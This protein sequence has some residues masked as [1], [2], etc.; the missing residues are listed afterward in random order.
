MPR[1]RAA[2]PRPADVA[3][4]GGLSP[5]EVLA[6]GRKVVGLSQARRRQGTLLQAGVLMELDAA[7]LARVLGGGDGLAA[8]LAAAAAGLRELVPGVEPDDV[9]AAVNP[10]LAGRR[11]LTSPAF[12][13][14]P[15]LDR[16]GERRPRQRAVL[17][18]GAGQAGLELGLD[19]GDPAQRRRGDALVDAQ[20]LG[21]ERDPPGRRALALEAQRHELRRDAVRGH[22]A[23]E[24]PPQG[25]VEGQRR[26]AV[27]LRRSPAVSP[28]FIRLLIALTRRT[29]A[30]AMRWLMR[31][32]LALSVTFFGV[33]R[34][35][36]G[37]LRAV[38]TAP[39]AAI[40]TPPF[41][42]PVTA[43]AEKS[44]GPSEQARKSAPVRPAAS[45][46]A[47][48]FARRRASWEMRW[49]AC[50]CL[51]LT[52]T[53]PDGPPVFCSRGGVTGR[54]VRRRGRR[55]R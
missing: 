28:P 42:A 32:C 55:R 44:F 10:L 24:G 17:D 41:W 25:G 1:A 15:G 7:R 49:L 4:F 13:A 16:R 37:V 30:W 2:A 3:C 48:M 22:A 9:V 43:P 45:L 6:G 21:G 31:S 29:A 39:A 14:G 35:R 12:L 54:T 33:A 52:V 50:S 36:V 51:A 20:L 8:D 11:R 53:L 23:G 26:R 5:Y 47:R 40:G 38:A 27:P 46:S 18:V 34:R 19:A